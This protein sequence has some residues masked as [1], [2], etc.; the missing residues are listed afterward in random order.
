MGSKKNKR[1]PAE[2]GPVEL[3]VMPFVDVFSLLTTFLLFSAVF[4]QIGILEVQIPF[5]SNASPPDF[6]KPERVFDVKIDVMKDKIEVRSLWTAEPI[7]EKKKE[8]PR[9]PEG[10]EQAHK[11]LLSIR[12]A[13]PDTDKITL[14]SD[15]EITYKELTEVLDAVKF[16]K[17]GETLPAAKNPETSKS[18]ESQPA[19]FPKVVMGS[20]ML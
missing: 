10:I 11:E 9:T 18:R 12:T 13:Q 7:D 15:D 17:E 8:F 6:D 5:L 14:F 20:V 16:L 2:Q 1:P 19:L 4:I 3:N